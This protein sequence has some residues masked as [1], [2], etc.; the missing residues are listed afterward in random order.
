MANLIRPVQ[1]SSPLPITN[2]NTAVL[3][4]ADYYYVVYFLFQFL[5]EIK[6]T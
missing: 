6:L 2:K 5:L 1:V 3:F 4:I